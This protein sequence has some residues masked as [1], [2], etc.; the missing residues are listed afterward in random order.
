MT[1]SGREFYNSKSGLSRLGACRDVG[2]Q[3]QGEAGTRRGSGRGGDGAGKGA[4]RQLM[5]V[6]GR[7]RRGAMVGNTGQLSRGRV[8]QVI[9]F[10]PRVPQRTL[11][12][13]C[14]GSCARYGKIK[15]RVY[16]YFRGLG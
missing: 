14:A 16:I 1:H 5:A 4:K 15:R 11:R 10:S 9:Y 7:E 2:R 6:R 8:Q 13:Y 12:Q 3:D